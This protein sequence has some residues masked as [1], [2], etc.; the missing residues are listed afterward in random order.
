MLFRAILMCAVLGANAGE[1]PG[2]AAAPA[3]Q[4]D[5][6]V[7]RGA[8]IGRDGHA[9]IADAASAPFTPVEP[10]LTP[11]TPGQIAGQ[12]QSR[13]AIESH[14]QLLPEVSTL[15]NWLRV[16]EKDNFVDLYYEHE[17]EP[18]AV[19]RFLRDAE[20][21]LAKYTRNPRIRA[22][23]ARFT[24]AELK[25][26]MDFMIETFRADRVIGGG[27][28]GSKSNRAD[29]V[30]NVTEEEF[31]ALVARK[32]V[33][34]PEAVKL[35]FRAKQPASSINRPLPPEIARLVRI[36]PRHDRPLGPVPDTSSTVK[37]E[38]RAGC[39][40]L[41]DKGDALVL[42]PLGA[43]L[44][45]DGD[46]YLAFGEREVPGYARVGESVTFHG[47]PEE[48]TAPDLVEPIHAACGPGKVLRINGME[49]EAADRAQRRLSTNA[50]SLRQL[51][52]MY[53][54]SDP[55][56]RK[57][58]E[59]CKKQVGF[60]TC[61]LTPPSPPPPPGKARC[62]PGTKETHGVCRT[63]EGFIRPLPQWLQE[64]MKG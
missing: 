44:F 50:E 45:V 56:A 42:F 51:K 20:A 1:Q 64:L 23:T 37:V 46:G 21:T 28:I 26:A 47:I 43:Q 41:A 5:R 59:A 7:P 19:V 16:A 30:I 15:G 39:F 17:G 58:L 40:R 25:A 63:P 3:A 10:G 38:L 49:S 9:T 22:A 61:I 8:V 34:I 24:E 53:G 18:H 4:A 54:L 32:G 11:P 48:M 14:R 60:G 55:V 52:T 12:E 33:T 29:V 36:F 2:S 6:L 27:G 13:R 57:A 31:R 62:P 35:E